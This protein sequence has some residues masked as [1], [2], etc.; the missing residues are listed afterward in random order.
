MNN[1]IF[2]NIAFAFH[3]KQQLFSFIVVIWKVLTF[4]D[5]CYYFLNDEFFF[6][7]KKKT[8]HYRI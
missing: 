5:I 2:V 6:D 7:S 1:L 3:V 8:T 4:N